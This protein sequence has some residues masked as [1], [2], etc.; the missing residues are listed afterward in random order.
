MVLYFLE[1]NVSEWE[2]RG[3]FF[4]NLG[5]FCSTRRLPPWI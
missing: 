2:S 5:C 4:V 1:G 3:R